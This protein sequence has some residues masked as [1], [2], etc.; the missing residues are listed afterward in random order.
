MRQQ[1]P[2]MKLHERPHPFQDQSPVVGAVTIQKQP[3]AAIRHA[4][5]D[6]QHLRPIRARMLPSEPTLNPLREHYLSHLITTRSFIPTFTMPIVH[7]VQFSFNSGTSPE[8]IAEIC[9]GMLG[10]K[11]KCI[12]PK[13]KKPYIKSATGGI[14]NSTEGL[15][16][17]VT[18][19]S[20]SEFESTED[21][22]YY[23]EE[24][25]AH[26]EFKNLL[27]GVINVIRVVDFEPGQF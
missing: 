2:P 6:I 23:V 5:D 14:D 27:K 24:D 15:Q 22:R 10:L 16:G 1:N 13:T 20:I 25:P 4:N 8:K 26:E 11:D 3:S 17:G 19:V 21:R 9:S 7:I 12:H 18:H